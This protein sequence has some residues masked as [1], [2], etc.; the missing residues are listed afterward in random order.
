MGNANAI[1]VGEVFFESV[2]KGRRFWWLEYDKNNSD[3]TGI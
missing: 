1:F 3:Y 2:V